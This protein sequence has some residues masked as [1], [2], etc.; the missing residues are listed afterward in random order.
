M[1]VALGVAVLLSASAGLAQDRA[2]Q[3]G[4][5]VNPRPDEIAVLITARKRRAK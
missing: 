5:R 2:A 4:E 1:R 3:L